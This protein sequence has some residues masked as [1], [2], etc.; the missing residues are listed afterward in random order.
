M[1]R[2]ANNNF[3]KALLVLTN[4]CLVAKPPLNGPSGGAMTIRMFDAL[5]ADLTVFD[6][7]EVEKTLKEQGYWEDRELP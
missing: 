3:A 5:P 7:N 4:P 2:C 6:A 1:E